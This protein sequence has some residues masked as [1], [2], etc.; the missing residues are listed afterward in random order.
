VQPAADGIDAMCRYGGVLSGKSHLLDI[1]A[2]QKK[3]K[4]EKVNQKYIGHS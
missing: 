4:K 3:K 1:T 2:L